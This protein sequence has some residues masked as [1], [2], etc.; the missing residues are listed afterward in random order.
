M[1]P[2]EERAA[3]R[4]RR[5]TAAIRRAHSRQTWTPAPALEAVTVLVANRNMVCSTGPAHAFVSVARLRFQEDAD[6]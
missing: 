1:T 6:G 3:R 2:R 4:W 5:R